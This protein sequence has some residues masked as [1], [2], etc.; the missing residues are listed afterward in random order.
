MKLKKIIAI[1]ACFGILLSLAACKNA[2]TSDP[3]VTFQAIETAPQKNYSVEEIKEIYNTAVQKIIDAQSY[4][5]YGSY[6]STTVFGDIMSSVVSSVDLSYEVQ[7]NGPVGFFDV[8]LNREGQELP[9]TTY[10][11]G[12]RYYFYAYDW[13]YFTESNDYTDYYAHEFLKL[14]GDS[15][16][17]DLVFMDQLD[18]SLEISFSL[19]M[20]EYGSEGILGILGDFTSENVDQDLVTLSVTIDAEGTLTY[21][22]ISF[23]SLL[24]IL[25]EASEQTIILSMSMDGYDSTTVEAPSDLSLYEDNV[26]QDVEGEWEPVGNLSPEDVS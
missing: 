15:E 9:H 6:S 24:E 5:M 12:E 4:H 22:Y 26:V 18:G 3:T 10:H 14:L 23:N 19:P 11:E 2:T 16:L 20:G 7:E 17:Q 1:L 8:M 25:G 21:F 13:K